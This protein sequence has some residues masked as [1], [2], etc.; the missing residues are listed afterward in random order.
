MKWLLLEQYRSGQTMHPGS[1]GRPSTS[2]R[3]NRDDWVLFK[4]TRNKIND[5]LKFEE[6]K[7]Q[8]TRL[9]TC[10]DDSKSVWK[11]LKG[12]LNW[13]SSGSPNKLF[14]KGAR[15]SNQIQGNGWCTEWVFYRYF[16]TS[17]QWSS[18]QTQW[19]YA[20]LP[21]Q[22][23]L[24]CCPP[25]PHDVEKIVAGLSNSSSFGLD[26]ND[27]YSIKLV[28]TEIVPALTHIINLSNSSQEFP[29]C[30]KSSKIIP[31]HKKEDLLNP[32]N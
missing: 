9:E 6:N 8:K 27:T 30:W 17:Y 24:V 10:G 19:S 14:Y 5:R 16:T 31:L 7:W 1:P 2:W 26:N 13:K 20:V 29:R 32:K 28:K 25:R 18:S 22:L 4:S 3:R 11:N 21:L 12:I 23:L 15:S